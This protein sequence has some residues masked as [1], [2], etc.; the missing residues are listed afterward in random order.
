MVG[1]RPTVW[2][3]SRQPLTRKRDAETVRA[4]PSGLVGLEAD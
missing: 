1:T 3:A 2:R 4:T